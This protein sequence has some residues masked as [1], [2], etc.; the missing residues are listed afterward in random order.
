MA[1]PWHCSVPWHNQGF[2]PRFCPRLYRVVPWQCPHITLVSSIQMEST[3]GYC[4]PWLK[5]P[6]FPLVNSIQM[7][8]ATGYSGQSSRQGHVG[9]SLHQS[10]RKSFHCDVQD[11]TPECVLI[12]VSLMMVPWE[13]S[14]WHCHGTALVLSRQGFG[15][16][17]PWHYP[18]TA[19]AQ[20]WLAQQWFP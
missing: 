4:G 14:P 19:L 2:M 18:C 6:Q 3:N 16:A 12:P 5:A 15:R 20:Q 13:M 17:V 9:P 7:E 1:R 10:K 11:C 8:L